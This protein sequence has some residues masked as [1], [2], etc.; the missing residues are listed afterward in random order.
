MIGTNDPASDVGSFQ[1]SPYGTIEEAAPSETDL[2]T[3][4]FWSGW[5]MHDRSLWRRL[6]CWGDSVVVDPG[7]EWFGEVC[8][9]AAAALEVAAGMDER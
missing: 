4:W 7:G 2:E 8:V 9:L 3:R 1:F 6:M 5:L